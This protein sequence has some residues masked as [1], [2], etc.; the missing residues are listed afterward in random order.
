M[1]GNFS[2]P[3]TRGDSGRKIDTWKFTFPDDSRAEIDVSLVTNHAGLV[4]LARSRHPL[5]KALEWRNSD[6]EILRQN[7]QDDIETAVAQTTGDQ[8]RAAYAVETKLIH[9]RKSPFDIDFR[10]SVSPL[11]LDTKTPRGNRGERAVLR[12]GQ[13]RTVIE[14]EIGENLSSDTDHLKG[15]LTA[16]TLR[17]MKLIVENPTARIVIEKND[18]A[19]QALARIKATLSTFALKLGKAMGPDRV[20]PAKLPTPDDLARFMQEAARAVRSKDE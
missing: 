13:P 6:I 17:E 5:L 15:P 10:I 8:W 1:L 16:E 3:H 2:V 7:V 12:D 4:F 14:M 18:H 19:D 20:D 9:P 11:T